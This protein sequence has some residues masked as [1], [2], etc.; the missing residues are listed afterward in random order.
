MAQR[1]VIAKIVET[2]GSMPRGA[3][4]WLALTED[5]RLTGTIGGGAIEYLA[6]EEARRVLAGKPGETRWY[7]R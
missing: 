6:I 2:R 5:G 4:A 3:G 7:T 1:A